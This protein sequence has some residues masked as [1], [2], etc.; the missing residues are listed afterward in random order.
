MD[1]AIAENGV[2]PR[3]GIYSFLEM[4]DDILYP[5]MSSRSGAS[6][7]VASVAGLMA[8]VLLVTV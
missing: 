2:A 3:Q 8:I 6:G 1:V 5:F 4:S 7:L